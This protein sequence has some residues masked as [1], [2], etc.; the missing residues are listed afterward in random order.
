MDA[1]R[2]LSCA[3]VLYLFLETLV[4][5]LTQAQSVDIGGRAFLDYFYTISSPA[6]ADEGLHGFTYRRLYLT[7]DF[8]LSDD[9]RG[10]ARLEANDGTSGPKGPVPFVKDLFLRWAYSGGH[11]VTLG[12]A[13]PPAFQVSEGVWGYRSLEK[14]ILDMQ[15]V[16]SSRDFGIRFDGPVM[17]VGSVRY[18]AML[19]NNSAT[20]PETDP[21]KR[22]YVQIAAFPT[23]HLSFTVG[24][25]HAGYEEPRESRTRLSG[26][27][28]YAADAF[29]LGLE[30]YW[31]NR[32]LDIG[33]EFASVGL[34][35]F[36]AV[37][38]APAWELLGRIDRA[39]AELPGA[40]RLTSFFLAGVAYAPN[41]FVR[42]IPN[43]WLFKVDDAADDE[44]L[45]RFT[46][47]V[48]F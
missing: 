25:D 20:R 44:L 43:I 34:S 36:G 42:L 8:Q 40:D 16:V 45:G 5:G 17:R 41:E 3:A 12:V 13:S 37:R 6:E 33:D 28:G 1:L 21:Y 31:S 39:S 47:D 48:R 15:D 7:A 29:R 23:E 35:L 11:S 46:V 4:P 32:F 2:R 24:A 30:G 38:L 9:F 19:A 26:F 10:R 18:A 14:T 27:G 22:G